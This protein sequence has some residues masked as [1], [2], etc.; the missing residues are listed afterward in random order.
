MM[1]TSIGCILAGGTGY[2]AK[3][4]LR[5]SSQHP[6]ITLVQATSSSASGKLIS[7]VHC[8]L[9]NLNSLTYTQSPDFS[10]L[11]EFSHR[12]L[13]LALPHGESLS[14]YAKHKKQIEAHNVHIIDLSGDFR[15]KDQNLREK[16]Y[17][18]LPE[19]ISPEDY[20]SFTYGLSEINREKIRTAEHIANP[21]CYPTAAILSVYPV[22]RHFRIESLVID[23][24]SGSS[25][26]GRNPSQAFHHPELASN[27]FPYKVLSHRHEPEIAEHG[28]VPDAASLMFVPHVL[29]LSRGM[30]ITSYLQLAEEIPENKII[31]AFSDT[32]ENS[33]FVRIRN[34]PPQLR[35]VVGSNFCD[36]N[37]SVRGKQLV[38]TA[39][40]DNLIKGMA[41]QAIQNINIISGLDEEIGL[42]LP[43]LGL[44]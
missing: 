39:C 12:F 20:A 29:P 24:K 3:E 13:L 21:G 43:G 16:H 18:A 26:A 30:M 8:E 42:K 35:H 7:D 32:Y 44:V 36:M 1:T 31:G 25:G 40:I 37:V 38:V 4:F 11:E 28:I 15:I 14:F 6:C 19:E 34:S 27:S 41:G 22:T 9:G 33:F 2:G 17:G 10:L 5:L 23:G